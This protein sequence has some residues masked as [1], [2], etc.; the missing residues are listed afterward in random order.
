MKY[1]NENQKAQPYQPEKPNYKRTVTKT[2]ILMLLYHVLS[3][4]VYRL[5]IS[6]SVNQ[7]ARDEHW[8]RAHWTLFGFALV[9]LLIIAAVLFLLYFKDGERKRAYL[10]A[11][12]VEV[13][14]AEY[15]AEGHTHYRKLALKEGIFCTV[16]TGI[17]WLIPALLYTI[18]QS[19]SGQGF[20]YG[21]AY[22]IETFFIGFVG[23]CEPFQNAF[24]GLLFGMGVLFGFHYFGRL[25]AHK[26]W[27]EDRMRR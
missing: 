21:S 26:K 27:A 14:G 6:A 4:L 24:V 23:L 11:T 5:F 8:S 19:A 7:L 1:Y 17:L 20:G 22:G 15:V 25:Y 13:R 12:S 18:F 3:M 16:V 2:L 9:G 10:T